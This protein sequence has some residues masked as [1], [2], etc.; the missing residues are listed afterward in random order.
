M[1]LFFCLFLITCTQWQL[2]QV[3]HSHDTQS[4]STTVAVEVKVTPRVQVV[5]V[6]K[7]KKK[8]VTFQGIMTVLKLEQ[9]QQ[10]CSMKEKIKAERAGG[11]R[12]GVIK[13]T[14]SGREKFFFSRITVVSG[15]R[16]VKRPLTR[17]RVDER[18]KKK[19]H[20]FIKWNVCREK[21][22]ERWKEKYLYGRKVIN[23]V[24]ETRWKTR[25]QE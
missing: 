13:C 10:H 22:S 14:H 21:L 3:K 9:Q 23:L 20:W 11:R 15:T 16:R 12:K 24:M 1:L 6:E 8:K 5:F 17:V 2:M 19:Q 7:M 18:E 4:V 25:K